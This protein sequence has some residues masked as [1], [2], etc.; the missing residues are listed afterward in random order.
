ME[1]EI[2]VIYVNDTKALSNRIY[3]SIDGM[4]WGIYSNGTD[5]LFEDIHVYTP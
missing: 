3:K 1:N 5:A 2:A 4:D